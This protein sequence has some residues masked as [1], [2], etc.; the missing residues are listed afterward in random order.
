MNNQL[1]HVGEN[2]CDEKCYPSAAL[3]SKAA[4]QAL[5]LFNSGSSQNW[6]YFPFIN[7]C[8]DIKCMD[9]VHALQVE[10]QLES[11]KIF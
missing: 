6:K 10:A 1:W 11:H 5:L 7:F 4:M 3:L 8:L 9:G 2:E